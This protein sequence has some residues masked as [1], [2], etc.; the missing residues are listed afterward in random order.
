MSEN[1]KNYAE[2]VPCMCKNRQLGEYQ[3]IRVVSALSLEGNK[4][5]RCRV[6]WFPN[7]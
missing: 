7:Y 6:D 4:E 2:I 3:T 1:K 5:I